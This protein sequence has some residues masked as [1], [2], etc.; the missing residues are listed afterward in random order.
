LA[1]DPRLTGD[2]LFPGKDLGHMSGINSINTLYAGYLVKHGFGHVISS[3]KK[4]GFIISTLKYTDIHGNVCY[5]K[6][7]EKKVKKVELVQS[8]ISLV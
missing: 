8:K 4:D 6:F 2:I 7:R 1:L 3:E 5:G